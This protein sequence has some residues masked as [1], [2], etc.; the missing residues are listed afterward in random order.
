M[1]R[2]LI[3]MGKNNIAV[4][5]LT[6]LLTRHDTEIV[7]VISHP[8]DS[9]EDGW[10]RSL[11]KAAKDS[12][13]PL[14]QPTK[15]NSAE[16]ITYIKSFQP[17][18]IFSFQYAQIIKREFIDIPTRGC[19]NL[20]FGPLPR[21]RGVSTIAWAMINCEKETGVTL[22]YMDPGIDT[23]DIIT[24]RIFPIDDKDNARDIYERC[25]EQGAALFK[26]SL[27]SIYAGKNKRIPQNNAHAIY[28]P[29]N[30]IDFS[31]RDI[32]WNNSTRQ[33]FN[34]IRAMIFPPFQ[35]PRC[36]VRDKQF[37]VTKISCDYRKNN[38]EKPGTIVSM[39][40][41]VYVATNDSFL[42]LDEIMIDGKHLAPPDFVPQLGLRVGDVIGT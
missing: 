28:Y 10:Q 3:V 4:E 23:G 15:V 21:Y 7:L 8:D 17:E 40:P 1:I 39:E 18:F 16:S 13:L 25:V 36:K 2:R 34:W 5:C 6:Y 27:D 20:H 11:T 12:R 42:I 19:V 9:G 29:K 22:H 30:S 31:Q 24:Q 33:L 38:F 35:Y 32:I 41:S 14:Y 26:D 37:E